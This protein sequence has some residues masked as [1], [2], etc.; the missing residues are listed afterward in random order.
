MTGDSDYQEEATYVRDGE[1]APGGDDLVLTPL[2]E[3]AG[4]DPATLGLIL[5]GSRGAGVGD[6]DSDYDLIWVLTEREYQ[7]RIETEERLEETTM[8]EDRKLIEI[9]YTCPSR[10]ADSATPGWVIQGLA[11]AQV[12]VDK[13]GEVGRA[14][15]ALVTVPEDQAREDVA[16]LFD[17]YLNGFY[18]SLKA[19]RRGNELGARLQAAESLVYLI[20]MLFALERR[21]PPFHDRL[22]TALDA[23]ERQ[24]WKPGEL[25]DLVL[26]I[27][28]TG[29]PRLQ[30]QLED[31]V[32]AL[33][34]ERGYG[35]V[36]DAW[37]GEIERVKRERG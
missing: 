16:Q 1:V 27:M 22:V 12:L 18:R 30:R 11:T 20:R 34:R 35:A 5:H 14:L 17:G 7:R 9:A 25:H 29:E 21:R 36:V 26:A 15:A 6:A 32:E 8:R 19:A 10:L 28:R 2:I 3:K 24:G 31:R 33:L 4:H 23:L 37:D 13:S